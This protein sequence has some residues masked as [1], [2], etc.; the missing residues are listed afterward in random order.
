MAYRVC[1]Q[2]R[3]PNLV[4][5]GGRCTE[6]RK[7]ADRE[8][9]SGAAKYGTR[10]RTRFR[11]GVLA[12]NDG[13]C[14]ACNLAPATVADHWPIERVDLIAQGLDPDDPQHGRP[15]CKRCHDGHTAA[16]RPAGWNAP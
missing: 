1:T 13:I 16:T 5:G 8:R 7:T 15:L 9:R 12:K 2:A 10:H 6:H 4:D 11:P 3:C 14:S